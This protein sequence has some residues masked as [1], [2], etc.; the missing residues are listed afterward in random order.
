MPRAAATR[1]AAAWAASH[2]PHALAHGGST[3][4]DLLP[5]ALLQPQVPQHTPA[6]IHTRAR[7]Q[8][9]HAQQL[10]ASNVLNPASI[11]VAL[12]DIGGLEH[13]KEEMV[14][15]GGEEAG[16][17]G[18]AVLKHQPC[19]HV[20]GRGPGT[21]AVTALQCARAH[22]HAT[23]CSQ[24]N[25]PPPK[26]KHTT[27]N[28]HPQRLK[29][30]RPLSEPGTFCTTLWRPVK[31]VLFYGPPGTGAWCECCS[32]GAG[33]GLSP[34]GAVAAVRV[35]VCWCVIPGST[36]DPPPPLPP[37][38]RNQHT[39]APAATPCAPAAQARQCWP[40]RWPPSRTAS[41]ST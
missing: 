22:T 14:R 15:G 16:G 39:R 40:R 19:V 33:G 29:V 13:I 31:G 30:L 9:P 24:P 25:T 8:R 23:P 1:S 3:A 12:A 26:K 4:T 5:A 38:P 34:A 2:S 32:A 7:S 17:R 35:Y 36:H 20:C 41:S 6:H 10:L 37:P 18:A 11:D 21:R 28:T 27:H